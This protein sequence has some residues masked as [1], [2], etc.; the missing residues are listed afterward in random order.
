MNSITRFSCVSFFS[1]KQIPKE[2]QEPNEKTA[3]NEE[4]RSPD[5]EELK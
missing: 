5:G 2:E 1:P 3:L 4:P